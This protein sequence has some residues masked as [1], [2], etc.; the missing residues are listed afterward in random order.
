M[1][2]TTATLSQINGRVTKFTT[3]AAILCMA[4]LA[5]PGLLSAS[6]LSGNLSLSSHGTE[7]V[8]VNGSQIDFD[9]T[10][11]ASTG[12]PPIVTSGTVDGNGDSGLFDITNASTGSYAGISG[13]TVTVHDLDN[14]LEPVGSTTG[15]VATVQL[16]HIHRRAGPE[17]CADG[18]STRDG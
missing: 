18:N 17:H 2:Q 8:A 14:S 6:G 12:F 10:G 13:T 1:H 5:R 11:T 7:T 9:F 3:V 15:R 4:G 16:H